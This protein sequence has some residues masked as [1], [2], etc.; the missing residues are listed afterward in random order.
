MIAKFATECF[1]ADNTRGL[2]RR[3]LVIIIATLVVG[4]LILSAGSSAQRRN[5]W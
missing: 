5:D 3:K 2:E 4:S 1:S